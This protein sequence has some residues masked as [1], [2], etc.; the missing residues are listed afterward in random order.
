M[1][2]ACKFWNPL[3]NKIVE[4]VD[5]HLDKYSNKYIAG[6]PLDLGLSESP[7]I[8]LCDDEE[9]DHQPTLSTMTQPPP[10]IDLDSNSITSSAGM[11]HSSPSM[12][13]SDS[14]LIMGVSN[15]NPI[16]VT[17]NSSQSMNAPRQKLPQFKSYQQLL[18]KIQRLPDYPPKVLS[19][20][21]LATIGESIYEPQT[22]I[23]AMSS[24][25]ASK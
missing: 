23:G 8:E 4:I 20:A 22:Y 9:N 13:I 1:G 11:P 14:S 6:C 10:T 24:L 25:E 7:Y 16:V 2:R 12:G 19:D 15:F 3:S 21:Y 5:Y 17:L 18:H